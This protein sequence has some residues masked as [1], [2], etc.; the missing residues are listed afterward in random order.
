M[1]PYTVTSLF[2]GIG[3]LDLG[4]EQAGFQIVWANERSVNAARSYRAHF[5]R[6]II[7]ADINE[8]SLQAIPAAQVIIGGP[9][10]QAF[11]LVGK[12]RL[13]DE[14]GLL[15]FR[16]VEIVEK[17]RP[18]A[19]LMEN[20]PGIAASWVNDI[21]MTDYLCAAFTRMGYDVSLMKLMATDFFVPQR[22]KR[23]FIVGSRAGT[24]SQP[25]P[26]V[27]CREHLR[28]EPHEF[29]LTAEGAI[30]DLG[31]SVGKGA[32]ADYSRPAHG[33]LVKLLRNATKTQV[34]LHE[35]PRMSETDSRLLRYVKPGGNYQDVPD[36][37]A[38]GRILKFKQTGGRTTTYGRLHP[39]RP[40]YTIN[41]YFRRPNVGCHFHYSEP[42]LITPREAMRFQS[43][44]DSLELFYGAQD[45]RNAF[46]GNAVPPL[47]ARAVAWSL[48]RAL[49]H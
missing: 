13:G 28:I 45:E 5:N 27:F 47:L 2:A 30:G 10:C 29:D 11:S 33:A 35:T 25:D 14:R 39:E 16:F 41:T 23:I 6:D 18:A 20:V 9:P 42:R 43:L 44:P 4:F 24:I 46:I 12:R 32:L 34:S 48:S 1:T 7:C 19:F 37:M 31:P 49:D 21:R 8:V 26:T 15:V 3:G 22:R 17:L 40:A 36:D 38:T